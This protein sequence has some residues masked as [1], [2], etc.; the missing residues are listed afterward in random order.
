MAEPLL[1]SRIFCN[2][3]CLD[4][5]HDSPV[6]NLE[7]SNFPLLSPEQKVNHTERGEAEGGGGKCNALTS[8]QV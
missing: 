1:L 5:S 7:K 3:E 8:A 4:N 2:D 6:Q